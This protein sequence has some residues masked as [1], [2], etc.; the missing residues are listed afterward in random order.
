M[1]ISQC[2]KQGSAKGRNFPG[3]LTRLGFPGCCKNVVW[4]NIDSLWIEFYA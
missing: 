3:R 2:V 1:E 4:K